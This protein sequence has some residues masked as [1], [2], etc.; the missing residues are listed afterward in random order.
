MRYYVT[1]IGTLLACSGLISLQAQDILTRQSNDELMLAHSSAQDDFFAKGN[2]SNY[3]RT[4][5]DRVRPGCTY[6]DCQEGIGTL[7]Y[8]DGSRYEGNF[9]NGELTGYGIWYFANGE[10]Y[11]GMFRQN[12]CHGR[13]VHYRRDGS[14]V[15]G[16]W[17]HG[18]FIGNLFNENGRQGCIEGN[19]ESGVGTY[20]FKDG[21]A[22]Y[23]GSFQNSKPNGKGI[24]HYSEGNWYEGNW[25]NGSFD[26]LGAM[27]MLDGSIISGIWKEGT[28]QGKNY[29]ESMIQNATE[30][31]IAENTDDYAAFEAARSVKVWAV[32]VGVAAYSHMPPLQYTDDDAYRMYAF[33]KSPEG[34]ALKD[35]QIKIL[36]DGAAT[37]DNILFAMDEVFR[38]AGPN[39]LVMMYYSGH[40]LKGSFLPIDFDGNNNRLLHSEVSTILNSSKAKYK[41]FIA[42]ACHSG[43]M[44]NGKGTIDNTVK[45]FYSS[46]AKAAPGT[47]LILSSKSGETSLESSGLRQGVFSHF[48]LRGL[49]GEADL[50]YNDIVSVQELYNY[51]SKNVKTYTAQQQSPVIEG[52]Y[53]RNMT[54]SVLR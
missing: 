36:V 43:S 41:L 50:D 10:K 42:D 22:R 18:T 7:E 5:N 37:K 2:A 40:G 11:I 48:L 6:G 49:K 15:V 26:G 24:C 46:L 33:L 25:S 14:K 53:D 20:I 30:N 38:K 13:G 17:E 8:S 34:G 54:V 3:T 16:L 27:Y 9:Q 19:C 28:Y 1:L 23:E 44:F 35:E 39:D 47:A 31:F 4:N 45:N 12:Y 29:H 21:K 52:D 32:V 51:I